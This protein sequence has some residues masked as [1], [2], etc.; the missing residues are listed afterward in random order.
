MNLEYAVSNL[1][2]ILITTETYKVQYFIEIPSANYSHNG[3]IQSSNEVTLNLPNVE[4]SHND[5]Q[6]IKGIYLATNSDKVNVIGFHDSDSHLVSD[7]YY[8]LPIIK[9]EDSYIHYGISVPR[10]TAHGLPLKSS[11]LII[12]TE[13]N[14]ALKL[15]VTQPVSINMSSTDIYLIPGILYSFVVNRLQTI[16]VGSPD[17]LSG[18][19]IVTDRP[20]SVFSGHECGNVPFDVRYC[21][22]LIEQIP[23]TALWGK[24]YYTVPLANKTSYTIK[25]LAAYASTVVN[26][27]CNNKMD[28]HRMDEGEFFNVTLSM[29][30]Y[31]AIHSSKEVLVV[32]FSHGG[33]EDNQFG[34]PMMTLVPST[35]QYLNIFDFSTIRNP[36]HTSYNYSHYV[37]IVVMKQYY[38]PSMIYLTAGALN[39]SL[40][41]EQWVPIQVNGVSEAYATQVIIPEGLAKVIHT[42]P[43]AQMMTIVYGFTTYYGSYGYV[44]GIRLSTG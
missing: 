38:Q 17:D 39:R 1:S 14:T 12:G 24:V 31:C 20:V 8:A 6:N 29:H 37:N 11:I 40:V 2:I 27:Y 13:D 21:N 42:N 23:P 22:H 3:I 35:N 10:A 5:D 33:D 43:A 26:I 9:L 4:V 15:M 34:N 36:L 16:Y 32:Q 19:K 7:S 41:A 18:T 25:I 30:E 44:G 28:L